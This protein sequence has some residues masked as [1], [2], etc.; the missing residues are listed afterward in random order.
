M[1]IGRSNDFF[2]GRLSDFPNQGMLTTTSTNN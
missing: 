2:M 1:L